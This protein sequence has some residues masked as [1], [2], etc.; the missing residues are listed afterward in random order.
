MV[1]LYSIAINLYFYLFTILISKTLNLVRSHVHDLK[2]TMKSAEYQ[3]AT[4]CGQE[5]NRPW[6][7]EDHLHF[8]PSGC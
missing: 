8:A 5:G 6:G 4:P 3:C 2:I 1:N 7:L